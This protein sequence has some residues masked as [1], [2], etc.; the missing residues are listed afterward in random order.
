VQVVPIKPE[1]KA[2][3]T[4]R[5]KLQYDEPLSNF[6]FNF[7]LRRYN[8]VPLAHHVRTSLTAA[9]QA[10]LDR[11]RAAALRWNQ[12]ATDAAITEAAAAAVTESE[13]L[14]WEASHA[15][16]KFSFNSDVS[17]AKRAV[18]NTAVAEAKAL[19]KPLAESEA[20]LNLTTA[21]LRS[22]PNMLTSLVSGGA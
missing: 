17:V 4:Q 8:P 13:A 11:A 16:C 22:S 19:V 9:L 18:G 5:L 1:L 3:R 7:N 14:A 10:A 6:A 2:R 12:Y 21:L 20:L 15:R